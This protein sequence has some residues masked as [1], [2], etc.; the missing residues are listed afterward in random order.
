MLEGMPGGCWDAGGD[1]GMLRKQLYGAGCWRKLCT[2]GTQRGQGG[3]KHHACAGWGLWKT[4]CPWICGIRNKQVDVPCVRQGFGPKKMDPVG[5]IQKQTL[6]CPQGDGELLGHGDGA[7]ELR[8]LA[9]PG[10][11][12]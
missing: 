8:G 3:R 6:G 12:S 1:S 9:C 5:K 10:G 2:H 4:V 11:N 7:A